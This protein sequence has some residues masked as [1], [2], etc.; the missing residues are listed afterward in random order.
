MESTYRNGM[1][2]DFV[3]TLFNSHLLH[4]HI[5]PFPNSSSQFRVHYYSDSLIYEI[6]GKILPLKRLNDRHCK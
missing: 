1:G 4:E 2:K 3:S 5:R 6:L